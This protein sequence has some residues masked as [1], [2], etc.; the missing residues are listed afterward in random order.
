M[1]R[2]FVS[3]TFNDLEECREKVRSVLRK[4][5][6]EDIAMEYFVAEDKR[7]LDKCLEAVASSDLYVGIFAWRYGYRPPGYDKSITELEYRK[8]VECGKKCLIFLLDENAAWPRKLMDKGDDASK[9]EELRDELS[10]NYVVSFFESSENLASLVGA[11]VNNWETTNRISIPEEKMIAEL[12]LKQYKEAISTRYRNIDLDALT[13]FTREDYLKIK[14]SS[15][16]VEQNV[17]ENPPPVELPKEI[18]KKLHEEWDPEKECLP[19]GLTAE[20]IKHAK[21]SYYSKE[22]KSV[23]DVISDERNKY[24]VILGDPGS[25]KSTLTKYIILSVLQ[26]NIDEKLSR[27]FNSHLPH[28]VELREFAGLCAKKDCKTFLDYFQHL[29]ETEGYSLTKEEVDNYL[30]EDGK[31]IVIFD[32][33]DEIF[34]PKEWKRINHMIVG[35]TLDYPKVRVIVTS[36]IVGYKRKILDDAGFIHFTLQDFEEEQIETF[37]DRWYPLVV[38]EKEIENRKLRIISALKNS[39]SIRQLAGNPLL[40]TIL[41][42][43]GKHQELPR[44]RWKLYDHAA[45][46]LVEKW[47]VNK[48]LKRSSVDMDFIGEDDKKELLM[49]IAYKMQ[50]G[51][52]GLAGNFIHREALQKEIED[53]LQSRY[54]KNTA[55]AKL[56]AISIIDQ[57]R[58]VNFILCLYGA[59]FYGFV[60][61]TFLEYFCAMD[62]VQKFDNRELDLEELKSDYFE[63]YWEDSTWHEVLSLVCGMKERFAGEIIECLMQAYNPQCF[64][65]R[66]PLNI[67]LAIKCLGEI[68]H[69]NAIGETAK[70]LL[71]RVLKLFEMVRWTQDINQFLAEEIVPAAK[72]VGERWPHRE[73]IIDKF[74]RSQVYM[75]YY[76]YFSSPDIDLN[77]NNTW[78]EFITVLDSK[79]EKLYDE[80]LIKIDKNDYSSLLGVL[81]LGKYK[82]KDKDLFSRFLNLIV[83]SRYYFVR[84]SAVQELARGWHEDTET[85]NI[86]KQRATNDEDNDVRSTSIRE[87]AQGW[88][89]DPEALVITKQ[90]ATNDES[91]NVRGTAVLEL[92]R[93]WH[94]DT[95]TL[96]IIKERATNDEDSTVRRTAVQ[97]LARGWP[98]DPDTLNI[99]K[100]ATNDE[101]RFVR[102]TAVLELARGWPEDPETLNIIKHVATNDEDSI[103]RST[104]V[105]ELARGWHDEPD[106]LNIIKQRATNDKNSNVRS[107]SIRELARGWHEDT[108]TLKFIKQRA[109]NDKNSNVRSTAVQEL[110]RGWHED[111]DT[112]NIIKQRATNDEDSDVRRTA[113][114]ELARGWH[115]DTET[116]NIIKQRATNDKNSH[117]RSTAVQ[118]LARGWHDDTETLNIIKQRATNDNNSYVRITAVE[119]LARGWPDDTETLNIIKRATNDEN[120][121]VRRTAVEELARGWPED[122]ETLKFIKQRATNDE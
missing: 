71:E 4:M 75:K 32:G 53:Y 97:E 108:E 87:L 122:P 81:I 64:G 21:E 41:A 54:Q 93:G 58:E 19:E 43:I 5:G 29:E 57:L 94:D 72:L 96:N 90:R 59:D 35:F 86:I 115:D 28:R 31:A 106:T 121:Y 74:S 73:I 100:R 48:H 69:P 11:A 34:D 68:R 50:S 14:L 33:L 47:E 45:S 15:V 85:L 105:K 83:K 82:P 88:H 3:S 119:E 107:T 22:E 18:W 40:L 101:E 9:I 52:E 89:D 63:K 113:V 7:P 92:A 77:L 26:L 12:D 62:I 114:Q 102:S 24:I 6:H 38:D 76:S 17:R 95:E 44:E 98:E 80:A 112:L 10:T 55:D 37:L 116:L 99:I 42:I 109:T 84:Q 25:G 2:I 20:D 91:R 60:H 117:V 8:A 67:S 65:N 30:R 70:E 51:P 36:R 13:P 79:S 66:P 104:A 111:T 78:A 23:L 103:V 46:V 27:L 110:A 16:F 120:S 49:K 56:I 118:E 1:A 61:R 39:S